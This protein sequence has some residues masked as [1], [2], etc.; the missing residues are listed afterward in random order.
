[1]KRFMFGMAMS[2]ALLLP[3]YAED[4]PKSEVGKR[5]ENQQKRIGQG[6]KSGQLTGKGAAKLEGREQKV[7]SEVK[8]D[9]AANGGHL[10]AAEK[11]KVNN[12]QNKIS[13]RIYDKKHNDVAQPGVTPNVQP[14]KQ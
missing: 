13:N 12:Q 1:M 5:A 9:R 6:L 8:A 10:T 7:H 2:A 14:P 11:A 3:M 4:A